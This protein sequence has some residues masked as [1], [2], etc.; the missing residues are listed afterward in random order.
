MINFEEL[1]IGDGEPLD[2]DKWNGLLDW[3][4]VPGEDLGDVKIGEL[5]AAGIECVT[6]RYKG[7]DPTG[8]LYSTD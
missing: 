6:C 1:R 8:L 5:V 3:V 2:K 4:G 7:L